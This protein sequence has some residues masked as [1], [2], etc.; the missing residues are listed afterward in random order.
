MSIR[1]ITICTLSTLLLL[2]SYAIGRQNSLQN[3]NDV[4]SLLTERETV[5]KEILDHARTMYRQG[6]ASLE[7]TTKAEQDLLNAQ[8]ETARS[9]DDR[10]SLLEL[11]VGVAEKQELEIEELVKS[12]V[13]STQELRLARVN[14]L[15]AQIALSREKHGN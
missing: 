7:A 2:A 1:T 12:G 11:Q 13:R 15:N 14:R 5:L 4:N 8:L 9:P 6:Q 10:I 3:Q